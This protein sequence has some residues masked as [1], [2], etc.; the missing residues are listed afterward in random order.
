MEDIMVIMEDIGVI[1]EDIGVIMD[2]MDIIEDTTD[3]MGIMDS[4]VEQ[5]EVPVFSAVGKWG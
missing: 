3:I 1:M 4:L 2:T 5:T